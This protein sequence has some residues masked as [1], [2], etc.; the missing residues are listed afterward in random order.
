MCL[1]T[2]IETG[3]LTIESAYYVNYFINHHSVWT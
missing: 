3:Q 1:Y 2:L